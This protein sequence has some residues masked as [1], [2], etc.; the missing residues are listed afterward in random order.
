[1][2]AHVPWKEALR[3]ALLWY[4]AI[5]PLALFGGDLLVNP[6]LQDIVLGADVDDIT[7]EPATRGAVPLMRAVVQRELRHA[8]HTLGQRRFDDAAAMLRRILDMT[9]E[10]PGGE[11]HL[12]AMTAFLV[13]LAAEGREEE[14]LSVAAVGFEEMMTSLTARS[15]ERLLRAIVYVHWCAGRLAD[16]AS[17]DGGRIAW[18]GSAEED[19]SRMLRL[20]ERGDLVGAKSWLKMLF[21]TS[22]MKPFELS[23]SWLIRVDYNFLINEPRDVKVPPWKSFRLEKSS[24]SLA[25]RMRGDLL[26]ALVD[27]ARGDKSGAIR[28]S[29]RQY[30]ELGRTKGPETVPRVLAFHAVVSGALQVDREDAPGATQWFTK[31]RTHI[32]EWGKTGLDRRSLHRASLAVDLAHAAVDPAPPDPIAVARQLV[33]RASTLLGP[34]GEDFIARVLAV[35]A[36]RELARRLA[37]HDPQE[38]A[39]VTR[40]ALTLARPLAGHGVPAWETIVTTAEREASALPVP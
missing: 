28:A 26:S 36:A 3:D 8:E 12:R 30:P 22:A 14:A 20:V 1:M 18:A 17:I 21:R 37:D 6:L 29:E 39:S 10:D 15:V 19:Q 4:R 35:Q 32:A 25:S 31:A 16:A 5:P 34:T 38:S 7:A 33:Q 27:L 9:Q 40:S 24:D 23:N 13:A 11:G 2:V